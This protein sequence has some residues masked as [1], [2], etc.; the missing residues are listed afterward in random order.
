M[1]IKHPTTSIEQYQRHKGWRSP[2]NAI[3]NSTTTISGK[4]CFEYWNLLTLKDKD[5][6]ID[7]FLKNW[8]LV[9]K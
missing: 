7:E 6:A 9:K 8:E 4:M 3:K 2:K 1:P 5:Q